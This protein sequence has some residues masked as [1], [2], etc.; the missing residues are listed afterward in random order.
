ML[1][2][3]WAKSPACHDFQSICNH[4]RET[5]LHVVVTAA[6]L[7]IG[8]TISSLDMITHR[9]TTIGDGSIMKVIKVGRMMVAK[10]L[11][12]SD[13]IPA[14]AAALLEGKPLSV[15]TSQYSP[16]MKGESQTQPMDP[17]PQAP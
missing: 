16:R 6:K 9:C 15:T 1:G 13:H 7:D 8:R 14:A 11:L 12:L 5:N 10:A 2:M 4:N 17:G 3:K